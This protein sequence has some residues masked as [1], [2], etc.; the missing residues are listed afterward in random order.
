MI[1]FAYRR[2]EYWLEVPIP[3]PFEYVGLAECQFCVDYVLV[4]CGFEFKWWK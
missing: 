1:L 2:T 3:S 4:V